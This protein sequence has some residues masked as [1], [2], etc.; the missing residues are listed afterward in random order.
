MST[1][2][3]ITISEKLRRQIA[4]GEYQSGDRLP[5]EHQLMETFG[6]SRIT[7]RQAVANLVSQGLAIAYR[8]KGVFVTPQK[9]VTYSL[10]SPLV[11]LEEDMT[12]QGVAFSFENLIFEVVPAPAEVSAE[13]GI[14]QKSEVYLQKKLLRMD[15]AAGAVDI[16]YLVAELGQ[17]FAPQLESQMT[18]PT[19][20]QNGIFLERLDATIECTHADYDLS[21]YLEVPLGHALMVYRYTAYSRDQQPVMHGATISRAD[22]FGYSLSTQIGDEV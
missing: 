13:M 4:V 3:H 9:K 15:G 2:L 1:P 8:G 20:A 17:R 6:V 12:R 18:F 11:F 14:L 16:S 21:T 10:T 7:A 5:S 22:R 19:L